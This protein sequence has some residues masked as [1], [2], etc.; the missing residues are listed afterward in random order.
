MSLFHRFEINTFDTPEHQGTHVDAPAHF[1]EYGWRTHQIPP[2]SLVGPA[3][4]VDIRAKVQNDPDYLF[5][6][7][8]VQVGHSVMMSFGPKDNVTVKDML[9]KN[10]VAWPFVSRIV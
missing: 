3:V 7:K 4:V 9:V 6:I 5:S 1:H 10:K 8:D 2:A